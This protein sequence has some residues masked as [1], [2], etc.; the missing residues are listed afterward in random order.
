M[1][2]K[3]NNGESIVFFKDIEDEYDQNPVVD[4]HRIDRGPAC[5][6]YNQTQPVPFDKYPPSARL[7]RLNDRNQ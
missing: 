1:Y 4:Y 5:C 7:R 6:L 2:N 3:K